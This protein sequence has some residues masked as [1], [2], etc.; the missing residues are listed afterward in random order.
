MEVLT[1]EER[2]AR[3]S[4]SCDSCGLPIKEGDVHLYTRQ[5]D[6]DEVETLRSHV[7][8]YDGAYLVWSQTTVSNERFPKVADMDRADIAPIARHDKGLAQ[9][10]AERLGFLDE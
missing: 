8:C 6:S 4:F 7:D 3:Q 2:I 9:R 1:Q 10:L 5:T